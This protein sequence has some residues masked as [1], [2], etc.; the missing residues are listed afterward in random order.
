[1]KRYS[2]I[3][4]MATKLL[5]SIIAA[6][7]N[8]INDK[9]ISDVI[10]RDLYKQCNKL[11]MAISNLPEPAMEVED[12]IITNALKEGSELWKSEYDNCR[13]ILKELVDLKIMKESLYKGNADGREY[14][15]RKPKAWEAAKQFLSK[16]QHL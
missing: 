12:E 13:D 3:S 10:I 5:N 7:P 9:K 6:D 2:E 1:M 8:V 11:V 4:G 14:A 15:E 16:Y